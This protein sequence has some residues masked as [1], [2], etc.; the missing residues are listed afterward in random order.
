M[1]VPEL[2]AALV[3]RG[4]SVTLNFPDSYYE[5]SQVDPAKMTVPELRA[6][7]VESRR[8]EGSKASFHVGMLVKATSEEAGKI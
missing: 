2:R 8:Q 4:P 7:L 3:E 5:P 6:A 1:T